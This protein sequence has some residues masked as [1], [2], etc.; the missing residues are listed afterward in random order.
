LGQHLATAV[1]RE[2]RTTVHSNQQVSPAEAV[3]IDFSEAPNKHKA[4]PSDLTVNGVLQAKAM[5]RDAKLLPYTLLAALGCALI[6]FLMLPWYAYR[7]WSWYRL[8]ARFEELRHP[9]PRSRD[10]ELA[11]SFQDCQLQLWAGMAVGA[12][13]WVILALYLVVRSGQT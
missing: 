1:G 12:V 2:T 4:V 5:V 10:G 6:G 11:A 13:L 7:L 8:N 3:D 9:N